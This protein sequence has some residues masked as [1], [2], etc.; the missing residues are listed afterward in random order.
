MLEIYVQELGAAE[1]FVRFS[2]S[3]TVKATVSKLGNAFERVVF[4][5]RLPVERAGFACD[6]SQPTRS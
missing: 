4:A 2:F 6:T 5:C 3:C 1:I